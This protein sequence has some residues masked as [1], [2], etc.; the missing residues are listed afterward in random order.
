MYSNCFDKT[1]K[2]K[3]YNKNKHTQNCLSTLKVFF[4]SKY[5]DNNKHNN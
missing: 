4:V 2:K 1:I 3:L 5:I